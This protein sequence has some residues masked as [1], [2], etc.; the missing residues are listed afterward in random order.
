[1]AILEIY[2]NDGWDCLA[3][4]IR[5]ELVDLYIKVFSCQTLTDYKNEKNRG[6]KLIAAV[7]RRYLDF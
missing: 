6:S 4:N 5:R 3:Y 7:F 1:M 2:E